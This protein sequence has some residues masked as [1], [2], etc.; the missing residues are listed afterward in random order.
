ML[1]R[2]LLQGSLQSRFTRLIVIPSAAFLLLVLGLVT[3]RI[4][5]SAV[6]QAQGAALNLA[7]IHATKLDRA[8]AEAAR[9]PEMHARLLE[10]GLIED[11]QTLHRY[12][13]DVVTRTGGIYGSCLAFQPTPSPQP[14]ATTAPTPTAPEGRQSSPCSRHPPTTTFSGTGTNSPSDWVTPC[15]SSPSSMKGVAMS[16]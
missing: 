6:E 2:R 9:V 14:S 8:L 12:L 11:Q 1:F 15:G 5:R 16:S 4:F 13:T 7:R 3:A 10:S